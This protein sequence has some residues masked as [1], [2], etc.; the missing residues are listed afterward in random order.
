METEPPR[1]GRMV[2]GWTGRFNGAGTVIECAVVG[3]DAPTTDGLL[4][5]RGRDSTALSFALDSG[6]AGKDQYNR[7]ILSGVGDGVER[8]ESRTARS[9]SMYTLELDVRAAREASNIFASRTTDRFFPSSSAIAI[10]VEGGM[11]VLYTEQ[12]DSEGSFLKPSLSFVMD[13]DRL[14]RCHATEL[15]GRRSA[16]DRGTELDRA[17]LAGKGCSDVTDGTLTNGT[18]FNSS[19]VGRRVTAG[20]PSVA[21]TD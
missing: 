2:S 13:L 4:V 1:R 10:A 16:G 12:S 15:G 20:L 3:A 19:K 8:I 9:G 21:L 14:G 6:G 18:D 7:M 11:D 17:W 5:V